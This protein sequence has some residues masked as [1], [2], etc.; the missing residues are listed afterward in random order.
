MG[1]AHNRTGYDLIH[2]FTPF[3]FTQSGSP[4]SSRVQVE[5]LQ[6]RP[7]PATGAPQLVSSNAGLAYEAWED[8]L[9]GDA[10]VYASEEHDINEEIVVAERMVRVCV[11]LFFFCACVILVWC[12]GVSECVCRLCVVLL[13]SCSSHLM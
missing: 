9:L 11:G 3:R 6:H 7:T 4:H 12:E 2:A 10:G 8:A 1:W 13:V 5:I